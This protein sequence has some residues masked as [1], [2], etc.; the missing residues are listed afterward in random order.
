MNSHD[1]FEN[2]LGR[3]EVIVEEA[4]FL[5]GKAAWG[6]VVRRSQEVVELALRERYCMPVWRCLM[7]TMWALS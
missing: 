3:A 1:G 6:L 7:P 4:E 5:Y 2:S